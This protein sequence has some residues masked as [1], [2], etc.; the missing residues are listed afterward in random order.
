[1]SPRCLI[2]SKVSIQ[3]FPRCLVVAFRH[4]HSKPDT[5]VFS[6]RSVLLRLQLQSQH[7]FVEDKEWYNVDRHVYWRAIVQLQSIS[8]SIVERSELHLPH[9]EQNYVRGY[10]LSGYNMRLLRKGR[11]ARSQ[12]TLPS[13]TR[14][15]SGEE[16]MPLL[17]RLWLRMLRHGVPSGIF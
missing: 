11:H 6:P 7:Q 3:S 12:R 16:N 5:R 15:A 13:P 10:V 17:C 1:M 2:C 8:G 9:I 14:S 4:I